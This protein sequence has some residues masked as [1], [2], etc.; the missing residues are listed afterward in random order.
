MKTFQWKQGLFSRTVKF[1][2]RDKEVGSLRQDAWGKITK[3]SIETDEITFKSKG[4]FKTNIE[5]I[6]SKTSEILGSITSNTWGSELHIQL[7]KTYTFKRIHFWKGIWGLY[8]ETKK[9]IEISGGIMK[10]KLISSTDNN[11][12]VLSTFYIRQLQHQQA[13]A[14]GVA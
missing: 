4:I 6:N 5:I 13:A 3:S 11:T 7:D 14:A 10:G 9:I 12:L 2:L 1:F 8:S